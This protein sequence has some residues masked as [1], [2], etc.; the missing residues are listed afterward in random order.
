MLRSVFILSSLL[1]IN[2]TSSFFVSFYEGNVISKKILRPPPPFMWTAMLKVDRAFV[3][4][5]ETK[6][7][8][9]E[10]VS[11]IGGLSASNLQTSLVIKDSLWVGSVY[12]MAKVPLFTFKDFKGYLLYSPAGPSMLSKNTFATTGYTNRFVFQDQF[13]FSVMYE[14]TVEF[15][16]KQYHFSN[17]DIFP[18]NGGID[19][20]LQFGISFNI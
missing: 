8:E 20:P 10:Y 13:G 2:Y 18:V 4:G 3:L 11:I 16:V 9:A 1:S 6:V 5:C 19:I 7:F 12:L 17:G 15:F 14:D